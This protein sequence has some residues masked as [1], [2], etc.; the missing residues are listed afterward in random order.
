MKTILFTGGHHNSAIPLIKKFKEGGFNVIFVGHKTTQKG[1]K[2]ISSEYKEISALEIPFLDLKTPKFYN[3][4]NPLKFPL[5]FVAF[6]KSLFL[7][8]KHKP[9]VIVSYGGYLAV[10]VC[11]AGRFL[12]I[13]I[14]THEQTVTVGLANG[15]ISKIANI[16][17]LSWPAVSKDSKYKYVG[18]PLRD[19]ILQIKPRTKYPK[20]KTLFITGGKQA[21]HT[22]NEFVF[23]NLEKLQEEYRIIH[24]TA[25]NSTN[26]DFQKSQSYM[27]SLGKE[28]YYAFD[29]IFGQKYKEILEN[30]DFLLS[31]SGAHICYELSYLKI[32]TIFV[33]IRGVS[34]NEQEENAKV[35]LDF[36]PSVIID[37]P[38]LNFENLQKAQTEL[39]EIAK[40][41][42]NWKKVP[43]NATEL[44]YLEIVNLIKK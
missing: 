42:T 26:N 1:N 16:V 37:E 20:F 28:K 38:N 22:L 30:S 40:K 3:N 31:R 9:K 43:T 15:L 21:S 11:F 27:D 13:K 6:I 41:N 24:Q 32:P 2:E 4:K 8:I 19:E 18:L 17:F 33:P 44:M 5:L 23:N 10:P 12:G 34:K 25:K 36:F 35:S 29:Y 7:I 14:V 39:Y